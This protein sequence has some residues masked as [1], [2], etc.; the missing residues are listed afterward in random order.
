MLDPRSTQSFLQAQSWDKG[1]IPLTAEALKLLIPNAAD[2]CA[3]VL[4]PCSM[5]ATHALAARLG[6][7]KKTS[8]IIRRQSARGHLGI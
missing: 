6:E 2:T 1:N 4:A 7:R 5:C 3:L 8:A